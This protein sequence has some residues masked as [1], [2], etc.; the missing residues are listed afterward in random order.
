[1]RE[2]PY[3]VFLASLPIALA[4]QRPVGS[5]KFDAVREFIAQELVMTLDQDVLPCSYPPESQEWKIYQH[6][7]NFQ[8]RFSSSGKG[9]SIA[10]AAFSLQQRSLPLDAH[11][12]SG[13]TAATLQPEAKSESEILTLVPLSNRI[14]TRDLLPPDSL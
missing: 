14:K 6:T 5:L 2:V 1:M 13:S 3:D 8:G 10:D 12:I 9:I 4:K 11:V 7:L